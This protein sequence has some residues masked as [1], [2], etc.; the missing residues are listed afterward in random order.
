MYSVS[1]TPLYQGEELFSF[2][3]GFLLYELCWFLVISGFGIYGLIKRQRPWIYASIGGHLVFLVFVSLI[4]FQLEPSPSGTY[5]A[6]W[7]LYLAL[8]IS[9]FG[10]LLLGRRH[11]KR[12][13]KRNPYGGRFERFAVMLGVVGIVMVNFFVL[14][15]PLLGYS[16]MADGYQEIKQEQQ[17]I[18][19]VR[20]GTASESACEQMRTHSS[21]CYAV[22]AIHYRTEE[23]R[24]IAS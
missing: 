18:N 8:P 15:D 21:L 2:L 6:V 12:R 14:T 24:A 7:F 16:A 13:E 19:G 17:I 9:S 1:I 10:G 5:W 3:L 20:A 4:R 23:T 11:G 22:A